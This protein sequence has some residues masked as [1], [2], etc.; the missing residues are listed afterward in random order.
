MRRALAWLLQGCGP[1]LL[2]PASTR[3][4][5]VSILSTS[6]SG[7]TTHTHGTT[8]T[9]RLVS[10]LSLVDWHEPPGH[11][12]KCGRL[13]H[14][15]VKPTACCTP[16]ESTVAHT[17]SHSC[18]NTHQEAHC[19]LPLVCCAA[20]NEALALL[21]TEQPCRAMCVHVGYQRPQHLKQTKQPGF[22]RQAGQLYKHRLGWRGC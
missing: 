18:I 17:C 16:T 20:T 9:H 11:V 14:K 8:N 3:C 13:K 7:C 4:S 1:H 15:K 19:Q 22:S 2:R 21:H 12:R 6:W 5:C 10:E